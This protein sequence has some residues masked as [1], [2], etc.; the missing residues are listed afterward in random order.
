MIRQAGIAHNT[1]K[2]GV[3]INEHYPAEMEERRRKLYPVMRRLKNDPNNKLKC[4][5]VRDKLFV[6]DQVYNLETGNLE[7]QNLHAPSKPEQQTSSRSRTFVN[8]SRTATVNPPLDFTTPNRFSTLQDSSQVRNKPVRS[9]RSPLE[10]TSVKRVCDG[11]VPTI[12]INDDGPHT[13]NDNPSAM[14]LGDTE[15]VNPVQS[16]CNGQ[17]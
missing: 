17:Q 3:Y 7:P 14:C 1:L 11:F 15:N 8:R 4:T 13:V 16:T 2:V 10:E 5:L 9:P 12:T 6:G